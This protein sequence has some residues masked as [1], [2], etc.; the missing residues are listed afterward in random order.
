MLSK[1]TLTS[2]R[3]IISPRTPHLHVR[4]RCG[5]A[6]GGKYGEASAEGGEATA[7]TGCRERKISKPR[8]RCD[9]LARISIRA[10]GRVEGFEDR[11]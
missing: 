7:R 11:V 9:A 5:V 3:S 10:W 2:D 6:S 8:S 1:F 4:Y